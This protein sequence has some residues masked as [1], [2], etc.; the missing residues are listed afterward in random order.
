MCEN[1]DL[2]CKNQCYRVENVLT[3]LEDRNHQ[4]FCSLKLELI[5]H[6]IATIAQAHMVLIENAG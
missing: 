2:P 1:F 5:S 3:A 4:A 6:K